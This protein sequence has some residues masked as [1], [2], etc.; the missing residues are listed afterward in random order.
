MITITIY[1]SAFGKD[2]PRLKRTHRAV[3]MIVETHMRSD[4]ER[5]WCFSE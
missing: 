4:T 1:C 3:I 5:A 2:I